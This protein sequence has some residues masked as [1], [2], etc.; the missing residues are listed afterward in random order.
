MIRTVTTFS[1][2]GVLGI[3]G[4]VAF[5]GPANAA[6]SYE[7]DEGTLSSGPTGTTKNGC[8]I[9]GYAMA[10]FQ[11]SGDKIYVYDAS[12]DNASAVM[13]WYTDYGRWGTCRNAHKAGTWAVCNKDFAEG[14][15]IHF[16]ADQ[17]DGETKSWVE[18]P[19]PDESMTT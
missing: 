4:V 6:Y 1:M 11:P 18:T 12:S 14:H 8:S 13:R 5:T 15:I 3:G 2:A 10:C 19:G 17:Y 16:H 9:G 7:W